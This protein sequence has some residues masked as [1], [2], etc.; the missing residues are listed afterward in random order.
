[1]KIIEK[2][3]DWAVTKYGLEHLGRIPYEIHKSRL[4]EQDWIPHME[5][6]NWVSMP[7]F[8]AALKAAQ[9]YH[10]KEKK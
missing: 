9:K 2:Y 10:E 5:E 4:W 8:I 7:Y 6:K 3:G 1:M